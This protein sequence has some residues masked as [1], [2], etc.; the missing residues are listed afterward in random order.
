MSTIPNEVCNFI[1]RQLNPANPEILRARLEGSGLANLNGMYDFCVTLLLLRSFV[2]SFTHPTCCASLLFL[3]DQLKKVAKVLRNFRFIRN[4]RYRSPSNLRKQELIE[5]IRRPFY[6]DY[7]TCI[8][9]NHTAI[10]EL[11]GFA[12]AGAGV[13]TAAAGTAQTMS[14]PAARQHVS[15]TSNSSS[16]R[17]A[18]AAAAAQ[19]VFVQRHNLAAFHTPPFRPMMI[20]VCGFYPGNAQPWAP[21]PMNAGVTMMQLPSGYTTPS[22]INRSRTS[23]KATAAASSQNKS[24]NASQTSTSAVRVKRERSDTANERASASSATVA[25]S[26]SIPSSS[27]SPIFNQNNFS[28]NDNNFNVSNNNNDNNINVSNSADTDASSGADTDASSAVPQ[29]ILESTLMSSLMNMGFTDRSEI[30]SSIRRL[31]NDATTSTTNLTSDVVMLDIISQREEAEEARKMDE[32]RLLSEQSRKEEARR[33]RQRN[34]ELLT[35]RQRGASWKEWLEKDDMFPNSWLLRLSNVQTALESIW[36]DGDN[37]QVKHKFVELIQLEKNARKWYKNDLPRS[38]F[39]NVL[40]AKLLAYKG[41]SAAVWKQTLDVELRRL[42][43]QMYTLSEQQGGVPRMFLDAHD[44]ATTDKTNCN[45]G[46][47]DNDDDDIVILVTSSETGTNTKKATSKENTFP[48]ISS[49]SSN[50]RKRRRAED[51]SRS[52]DS[53]GTND[54]IEIV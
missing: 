8:I 2:R 33:L 28:N 36:R 40:A 22:S 5:W 44:A 52:E 23:N 9:L 3:V 43:H 17:A 49:T 6:L 12:G 32:A 45:G 30:L 13:T 37:L 24:T 10:Q 39:V 26:A 14:T 50:Q 48:S 34:A 15:G 42:E 47:D 20:P 11:Q 51:T 16:G 35:E 27:A 41:A 38:Y 18:A 19:P 1:A 25:A 29:T 46:N 4:E 7:P 54:V 21:M 31:R 53:T